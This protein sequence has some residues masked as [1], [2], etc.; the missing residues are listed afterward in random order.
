VTA[1]SIKIVIMAGL[2]MPLSF[3]TAFAGGSDPSNTEALSDAALG[4]S[5]CRAIW[6]GAAAGEDRLRYDKVAAYVTDLQAADPDNDGYFDKIEFIDA[7]RKGFVHS[8]SDETNAP[9][10]H[11]VMLPPRLPN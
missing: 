7:C 6:S 9:K 3:G 2:T 11:H 4:E 10:A 5:A 1:I 8:A